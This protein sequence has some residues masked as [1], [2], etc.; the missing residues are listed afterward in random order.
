MALAGGWSAGGKTTPAPQRGA[1]G[2]LVRAVLVGLLIMGTGCR[3]SQF[4]ETSGELRVRS[5]AAET[6][7]LLRNAH[8]YKLMGR[9]EAA[10]KEMEQAHQADPDNLKIVDSLAQTYQT[11]GKFQRAQELYQEA[12]ARHGSNR[13]L[14]NN[15]CFSFYLQGDLAKAE[16]CFQDAL[17]RDPGNTA[18]RNNL[19]LLWCHQGKVAQA[20]RLWEE[21]EGAAAAEN[22]LN[23]ALAFL[24]MSPPAHYAKAVEPKAAPPPQTAVP[25]K[26]TAPVIPASPAKPVVAETKP[27]VKAPAQP[28]VTPPKAE[29]HMA[30]K[31]AEPKPAPLPQ[32]AAP[33]KPAT[34]VI[35]SSPAKP[36]VAETKP[37]VTAQAAAALPKAEVKVATKAVE[38]KPAP[39]PQAVA[40]AKPPVPLKPAPPAKSV[41]AEAKTPVK[42]P[43]QPAAAP[44][45]AEVQVA[46]KAV[47]PK[48]VPAPQAVSPAKPA[49]PVKPASPAKAVMA[50]T[51]KIPVKAPA[52]PVVVPPK[53]ELQV[54]AK[55]ATPPKPLTAAERE[56]GIEVRNGNGV[57]KMAHLTGVL[58]SQEVFNVVKIGNHIDFGAEATL[59]YYRPEAE[60]LA[61]ALKAE[62][63]P[64]AGLEQSAGLNQ[65]VAVK[66]LLGHDL[67][68]QPQV[69][70]RLAGIMQAESQAVVRAKAAEPKARRAAPK[71]VAASLRG[72]AARAAAEPDK[73]Q[74]QAPAETA[75]PQR[76]LTAEELITTRIEIRNG[77]R[78]RNLAHRTRSLLS[79]Q[80]FSVGII[81][82][83]IDFGAEVTEIYYRPGAE[84]V[85]RALNSE[86]FPGAQLTPSDK[87]KKGM[88]IKVVLGRDLLNRTRLMSMLKE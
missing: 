34:P 26:P 15:W 53:A 27:P 24:G 30:V 38:P 43:V 51:K 63:F 37:P 36:V 76:P 35:P 25:V 62:I 83:H 21:A 18:A 13:A 77:T 9:P 61:Q 70:V 10:L 48:P 46:D 42:A 85:A 45:K 87:L 40:P 19:G 23:Q 75:T 7:R 4:R 31:A 65:G 44:P 20:Q 16:S 14:Q 69:M 29:V 8:Y 33:A 50:V 84:K 58:L 32:A 49:V 73:P 1:A 5:T 56:A 55:A 52:Q 82:N 60:R 74:N 72:G 39:L 78:S 88:A 54:A 59:I 57:N 67:L 11:L 68:S 22:R 47:E 2:V 6:T 17:A 3:T 64:Q 41:V 28:A 81:G 86:I 71:E 12:L 80:G 79:Q 66:I